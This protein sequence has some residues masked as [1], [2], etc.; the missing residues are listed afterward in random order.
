MPAHQFVVPDVKAALAE[1]LFP[2]VLAWNRL[3]GRPRKPN[4]FD[5]SLAAEIR[6]AAWMLTRQWQLGEFEGDDAG[7]PVAAQVQIELQPLVK[8]QPV[9]CPV[10]AFRHDV[11]LEA[12][13]ERRTIPFAQG[14]QIVA[15][16][17]RLA[18]GRQWLKMVAP[19]GDFAAFYRSE[20]PIAA[21]DPGDPADAPICA[22]PEVWQQ[23][24]AV[25]GRAMDGFRLYAH[26]KG[27]DLASANLAVSPAVAAQIDA[28]GAPFIAWF[29]RLFYQ[30]EPAHDAWQP[31]ALEYRFNCAAAGKRGEQTLTA[32]EY[33]HGALDWYNFDLDRTKTLPEPDE[34]LPPAA[35]SFIEDTF[36][37]AG[38]TFDG[39]PHTRWWA[40]EDGKTNFGA[41]LPKK[42]DL[43]K[44]L[45][46][47]FGLVYANDW[48]LLPVDVDAGHTLLV[49]GLSVT[50]VFGERTWIDPAARAGRTPAASQRWRMFTLEQKSAAA[51]GGEDLSLLLLPTAAKVQE[52]PPVDEV[53]MLRDEVAN[54]V[55]G[56]ERIVPLAS[57]RSKPGFEAATELRRFHVKLATSGP[58]PPPHEFEAAIRYQ[59]MNTV[60]ENWIPF[61]A[62]HEPGDNRQ[63][64]LQ[65]AV[66]PRII[67]GASGA[68]APVRPRSVLL[69][70]GVDANASYF[71]HEEE[72]P[73][74]GTLVT[75]R[76][77]RTRWLDGRVF[78]W[79]GVR[80]I[81]GRGEG[82]SGLAF[83]QIVPAG[84][85]NGEA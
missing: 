18:M 32:T 26:L 31:S 57:G 61:I 68:P 67:E 47:E 9:D 42:A 40:F 22:H 38:V 50:N 74:A 77:Q 73:R 21:P 20:Y 36:I 45:L 15:L 8:Y 29:E 55:W 10:Q 44:L 41:L 54:M 80:K 43:G 62:V 71:V 48:F 6:D 70:E 66:L 1:R 2:T 63:I 85:A 49:K 69:R 30:P 59:V 24:A 12:M 25:A 19:I 28:V 23:F 81:T 11:P 7:S 14:Q 83:D 52:G 16:D 34:G 46:V 60:P 75:H 33:Y 13:V 27:G 84:R 3:E 51:A 76:F 72:V 53:L 82:H 64:R 78:T 56:V 79:L 35:S 58:A 4:S 17:L 5:R 39:M 65:R 37:P